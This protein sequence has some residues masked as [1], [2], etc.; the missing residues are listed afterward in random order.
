MADLITRAQLSAKA[1]NIYNQQNINGSDNS[2]SDIVTTIDGRPVGAQDFYFSD[3][4]KTNFGT[5]PNTEVGTYIFS[6]PQG[7]SAI[8]KGFKF[9]FEIPFE[10]NTILTPTPYVVKASIFINNIPRP[11][12]NANNLF[13]NNIYFL[14]TYISADQNDIISI[15]VSRYNQNYIQYPNFINNLTIHA[16]G[17]FLQRGI[18]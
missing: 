18:Q 4:V 14:D 5:P 13:Q 16:K 10:D 8:L 17:V 15:T 11:F 1:Q 3:I 2:K 7:Y 12:F 9:A 6:V